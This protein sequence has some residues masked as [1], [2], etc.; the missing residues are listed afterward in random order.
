[1]SP[2]INSLKPLLVLFGQAE[3]KIKQVEQTTGEGVL[4]PSINQLRYAGYH[5]VKSLLADDEKK[6]Q[7]EIDRAT[8]HA[9]RAIYDIDEALLIDC[10]DRAKIFKE[11]YGDSVFITDIIANYPE[12]LIELDKANQGIQNLRK[13][14]ENYKNRHTLYQQLEPH[15]ET[16]SKIIAIFEQSAH[17]IAKKEEDKKSREITNTRRFRLTI[18]VALFIGIIGIYISM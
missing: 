4:L 8:N 17:L 16:L 9:K 5:I 11:K 3:V 14:A 18:I 1:M 6:N 12:Q 7:A 15:L 10:L 13:N 2:E